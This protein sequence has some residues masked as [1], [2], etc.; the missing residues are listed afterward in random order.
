ME[1]LLRIHSETTKIVNAP[2]LKS[3]LAAQGI[4]IETNSPAEFARAIRE[5]SARWGKV[6]REAGI[7]G[8]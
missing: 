7:K 3:K 2:D 1:V 5:D 6:I 8:E 4:M